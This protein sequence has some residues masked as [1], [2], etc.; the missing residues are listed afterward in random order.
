MSQSELN[1]EQGRKLR[2]EGMKRAVD[3]ANKVSPGWADKAYR[4][5]TEI[6]LRDHNGSF[7]AEEVRAYAALMDIDLPPSNRAW[8]GIF[9]KAKKQ[10]LIKQIDTRKVTNPRAHCA[11][12]AVWVQTRPSERK[13]N[14]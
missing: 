6:F 12:A 2:D 1:F 14:K 9:N 11:N 5:F 4:F 10:D 7:M 13:I 8:G 3:H